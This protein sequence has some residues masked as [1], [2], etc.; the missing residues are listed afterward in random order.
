[1]QYEMTPEYL[2]SLCLIRYGLLNEYDLQAVPANTRLCFHSFV[3]S[4]TLVWKGLSEY[5][6]K[7]PIYCSFQKLKEKATWKATC[8]LWH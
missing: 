8:I 7:C 5:K 6:Q 2:F 3:R 1:M 4:V